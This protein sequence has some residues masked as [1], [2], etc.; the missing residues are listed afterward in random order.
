MSIL[1][2]DPPLFLTARTKTGFVDIPDCAKDDDAYSRGWDTTA[3]GNDSAYFDGGGSPSAGPPVLQRRQTMSGNIVVVTQPE[4]GP[5]AFW[6]QR[7]IGKISHG[8]I[9]LGYKLRPNTKEAFKDS[10][11]C[12]ELETDEMGRQTLVTIS[13]M[14]SSVIDQPRSS[15]LT[16]TSTPL[17]EL[18][19][20]QMICRHNPTETAHVVGT[21]ILATC[22]Q[23]VYAVLPYHRDGTLLQ[24]CQSVGLLEEPLARFLFRQILQVR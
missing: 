9:R 16:A 3:G 21:N 15:V 17:D 14:H 10:S 24:F 2:F 18:S 20:L 22:S 6:L 12:W 7:K 4:G 13:I 23:S 19:A 5:L 8:I 11:D 1:P